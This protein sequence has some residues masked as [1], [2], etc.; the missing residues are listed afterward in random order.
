M[1]K[2]INA[3]NNASALFLDRI[4]Q[5]DHRYLDRRL[6]APAVAPFDQMIPIRSSAEGHPDLDRCSTRAQ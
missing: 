4:Y 5:T 3:V 1:K 2:P 6:L